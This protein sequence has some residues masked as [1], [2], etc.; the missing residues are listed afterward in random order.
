MYAALGC[1]RIRRRSRL[2]CGNGVVARP[3]V[4]PF[5]MNDPSTPLAGKKGRAMRLFEGWQAGLLAVAIALAGTALL[6]PWN[7]EPRDLPMPQV[8]QRALTADLEHDRARAR[9]IAPELE[10]ELAA[11][12]G[13][14][15]FDL[16][17][18]GEAFRAFGRAEAGHDTY[19]VVRA[20]KM[21]AEALA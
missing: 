10:R 3:R 5:R 9:A 20:R 8:D 7:A 14:P 12:T 21:L 2:A 6:L 11:G 1:A 16:R 19:E 4:F 18:F 13:G 17:R 15:L